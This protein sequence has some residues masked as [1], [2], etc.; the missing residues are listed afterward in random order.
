VGGV[1]RQVAKL[2]GMG[3]TQRAGSVTEPPTD[4]RDGVVTR[5]DPDGSV[6]VTPLDGDARAPLGPVLG[7]TRQVLVTVPG[8]AY[9]LRTQPLPLR[10]RVLFT[11]TAAAVWIVRVDTKGIS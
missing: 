11:V 6:W 4:L 5:V 10:C 2:L 7:A 9:E 3:S 8:G 1:D